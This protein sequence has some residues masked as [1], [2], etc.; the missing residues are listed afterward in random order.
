MLLTVGLTLLALVSVLRVE[1]LIASDA[2]ILRSGEQW[3]ANLRMLTPDQRSDPL[4]MWRCYRATGGGK[5]PC[6]FF[7]IR[8]HRLLAW[9]RS[10]TR[11]GPRACLLALRFAWRY[12]V[13]APTVSIVVILVSLL[14]SELPAVARWD[15]LILSISTAVGLV[16]IAAEGELASLLLE[17]WAVEYHRFKR[18]SKNDY[19]IHEVVIVWGCIGFVALAAVGLASVCA[20]QF[21]AYSD[22]PHAY[23]EAGEF[24]AALQIAIPGMFSASWQGAANAVGMLGNLTL[25]ALYGSYF[26]LLLSSGLQVALSRSQDDAPPMGST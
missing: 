13:F 15:L 11:R 8:S 19:R 12:F 21:H 25:L 6:L 22:F 14:A 4:E 5:L 7:G 3:Q 16:A 26:L 1:H 20:A 18:R 23:S 17:S 10:A 9:Q 2:W 24:W